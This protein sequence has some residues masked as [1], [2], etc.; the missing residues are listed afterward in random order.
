MLFRSYD[1]ANDPHQINYLAADPKQADR[2]KKMRKLLRAWMLEV[3]DMGFIPECD[4]AGRIKGTTA[5]ELSRSDKAPPI[6]RII[7]AAELVGAGSKEAIGKQIKLLKDADSAVRY[8][9][10]VGLRAIGRKGVP[11][12]ISLEP[13]MDDSSPA[14]RIEAAWGM[15]D[16]G[17]GGKGLALLARELEGADSR[18]AV[19]AA[20]ALQ[21][22]GEKARPALPAMQRALK[23]SGKKKGDGAMFVRFALTPAVKVLAKQD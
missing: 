3:K 8:W 14:V 1:T 5:Y 4:L 16:M 15:V 13:A 11:I 21:M 22:L 23:A 20:R 2:I 10:A 6:E 17:M 7:D 19:R 9:A 12:F 18:A